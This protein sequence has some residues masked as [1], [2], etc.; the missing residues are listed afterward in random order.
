MGESHIY[1]GLIYSESYYSN[2][3][4]EQ[5]GEKFWTV[6][7]CDLD[8][9]TSEMAQGI[10]T[11]ESWD[12]TVFVDGV[13]AIERTFINKSTPYPSQN[14]EYTAT[15]SREIERKVA[16]IKLER[17]RL[18]EE[19]AREAERERQRKIVEYE[20]STLSALLAK[21]GTQS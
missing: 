7:T 17:Q 9:F 13:I 10:V 20:K 1:F 6:Y 19:Q 21:Y 11:E 5:V 18:A 16:E 4:C 8:T 15:I 14:N 12:Y 3:Y 2:R